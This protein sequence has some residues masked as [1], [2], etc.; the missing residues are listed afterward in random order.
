[1]DTIFAARLL[2]VTGKA[3][4]KEEM[5][6]LYK[7]LDGAYVEEEVTKVIELVGDRDMA[8]IIKA[9]REKMCSRAVAAAPVKQ[10]GA[11][12]E[13]KKEEAKVEAE[14]DED[15]DMFGGF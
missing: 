9:G 1:M 12:K 3:L 15:F 6:G 4:N 14:E 2:S 10:E 13:T 11:A 5:F 7:S 8:E